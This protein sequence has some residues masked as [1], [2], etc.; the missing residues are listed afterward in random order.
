MSGANTDVDL[1]RRIATSRFRRKSGGSLRATEERRLPPTVK[2]L[3]CDP[4]LG[5]RVPPEQVDRAR[6]ALVAP[7]LVL[8][9]GSWE[10]PTGPAQ[11][12]GL[13]YL[14]LG[15]I[16]ARDVVLAGNTST[17]LLGEGDVLQPTAAM[18]DDRL[19]R[20]H[21]IWR[22]V[23]PVRL[24]ALGESFAR[25]LGEWPQVQAALFE[26]AIRRSL[27]MSIHQALLQLSPVETRLL[28]VFWYLAERWGR[29]TPDGIVL[30]LRLSHRLLGQLVG[31]QRASVTTALRRVVESGMV[32]RRPDATWLLRGSPPDEL[33]RPHWPQRVAAGARG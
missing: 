20:C 9:A 8:D 31:S 6:D 24:A 26:R 27:H 14:V 33:T 32:V 17:E 11:R 10:P 23:E 4:E 30:R 5:L 12:R 25:R 19:V 22:V 3:E 18:S 2:V 1:Q 21:V 13:G 16:L 15:G 29:V 7:V 28:V